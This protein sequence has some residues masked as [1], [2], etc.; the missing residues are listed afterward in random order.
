MPIA[1]NGRGTHADLSCQL[2]CVRLL[3][4]VKERGRVALDSAGRILE[5]YRAYLAPGGQ[6]GVGDAFYKHLLDNRYNELYCAL[7][8]LAIDAASGEYALFPDDP[9]LA[10]FDR[11]DRKFVAVS[12]ACGEPTSVV[13]ALD[14]DWHVYA[15]ALA[16]NGI[17]VDQ[18]CPHHMEP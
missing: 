13:N 10:G 17:V 8:D 1:A 15:A 6:P 14:T 5:E 12:R 2:A 9:A 7:V 3:R 11:S 16:A 18:I 4:E